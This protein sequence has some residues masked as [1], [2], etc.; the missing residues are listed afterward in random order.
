MKAVP[1]SILL[2]SLHF[3][4]FAADKTPKE[5]R[6]KLLREGRVLVEGGG[7]AH[8][9]GAVGLAGHDLGGKC[10]GGLGEGRADGEFF[11]RLDQAAPRLAGMR[12]GGAE[13]EALDLA[14]RPNEPQPNR[15]WMER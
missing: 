9:S 13:E 4:V 5:M 1:L 7:E 15:T 8:V 11:A 12:L 14:A 3:S 10:A 2:L 6:P